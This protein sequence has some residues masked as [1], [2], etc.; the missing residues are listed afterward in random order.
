LN[1][2]KDIT[3]VR[4]GGG[5]VYSLPRGL[6]ASSY[7]TVCIGRRTQQTRAT[8]LHNVRV[9]FERS[10]MCRPVRG[11]AFSRDV[12][13]PFQLSAIRF[14]SN[15]GPRF[16]CCG[17]CTPDR[18]DWTTFCVSFVRRPRAQMTEK[19]IIIICRTC[20]GHKC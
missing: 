7:A 6:F 11:Y 20:A 16:I 4:G 15:D 3:L 1:F 13:C 8:Q 5:L 9:F 19:M 10:K 2:D 17:C 18:F 14:K 12:A